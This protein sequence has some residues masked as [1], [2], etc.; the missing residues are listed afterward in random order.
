MRTGRPKAIL[1]ISSDERAHLLAIARSRSLPAALTL[2]AKIVSACERESSNATA[3]PRLGVGPH[4]IGNW[5]NRFIADRIAGLYD[6][7]RSGGLRTVEDET[8]AD[9]ITKTPTRKPK[10]ATHWSVR[11]IAK[12]TGIAKSTVHRLFQLFGLQPHRAPQ[13]FHVDGKS[14]IQALE[15]TQPMLPWDLAT[16]KALPL[17]PSSKNSRDVCPRISAA[18]HYP[19]NT[20]PSPNYLEVLSIPFGL[21]RQRPSP[22]SVEPQIQNLL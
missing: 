11:A 6:E 12:E 15:R 5:R 21:D 16:S 3:A 8:V 2:R 7:M 9:L 18:Q 14:Q 4:T 10:T 17:T 19:P 1:T 22:I 20:E 13:A